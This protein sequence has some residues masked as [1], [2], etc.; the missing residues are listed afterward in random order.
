MGKKHKTGFL[1][2][3]I[4]VL[5]VSCQKDE[6]TL[7]SKVYFSFE[8]T[9]YT[10]TD[11]DAALL[12]N[13]NVY[14]NP[15]GPFSF[16]I[17]KGQMVISAIEFDG[18]RPQGQDVY[19]ISDLANPIVA[20]LHEPTIQEEIGFDIPQGIYNRIDVSLH[21]GNTLDAPLKIEGIFIM[22]G[23]GEI[24]M[25][26]EYTFKD[27]ITIRSTGAGENIV[28]RKDRPSFARV[29]ID[30]GSLFGLVNPAV[31]ANADL[32]VENGQNVLVI[33]DKHNR[34]VF[35]QI[36]ARMNQAFSV[37]FD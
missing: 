3:F 22:P 24:N 32:I 31:L 15:P 21:L 7:P 25:R 26:F 5:A 8:M 11:N 12:K 6:L 36:A 4:L 34:P 19:F 10:D 28:L 30:T 29:N 2:F 18:K 14:G 23:L 17:D 20:I 27:I 1:L 9:S 16:T 13:G 35:N 33:S 37:V